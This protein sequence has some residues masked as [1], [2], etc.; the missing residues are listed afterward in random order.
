MKL[1]FSIIVSYM[2]N[3][4]GLLAADYLAEGVTVSRSPK[5][6]LLLTTLLTAAN[7]VLRP[8]LK[9]LFTPVIILSLGTFT[10]VINA[11]ILFLLDSM[12]Q[13]IT[14]NGLGDLIVATILVSAINVAARFLTH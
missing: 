1:F 13:S 10:L 9:F 11:A 14:I 12:S 2:G 5:E 3:A 6:F 8:F 4:V 7:L